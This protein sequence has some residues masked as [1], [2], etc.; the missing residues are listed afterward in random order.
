MQA[1]IDEALQL[2]EIQT[3]KAA[4]IESLRK[5]FGI[6]N[7][8]T[9]KHEFLKKHQYIRIQFLELQEMMVQAG[10]ITPQ[11]AGKNLSKMP[12][13]DRM[14]AASKIFYDVTRDYNPEQLSPQH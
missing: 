9:S 5:Q 13:K 6:L 14:T 1:V 3:E 4:A 7:E 2:Q 8:A 10:Y 11:E 12:F